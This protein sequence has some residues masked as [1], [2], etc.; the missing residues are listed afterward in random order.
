MKNRRELY[1]LFDERIPAWGRGRATVRVSP[2]DAPERLIPADV[3]VKVEPDILELEQRR[4]DG[5]LVIDIG[6][7]QDFVMPADWKATLTVTAKQTSGAMKQMGKVLQIGGMMPGLDPAVLG[8]F[9]LETKINVVFLPYGMRLISSDPVRGTRFEVGGTQWGS[10]SSPFIPIEADE[11]SV[12]DLTVEVFMVD[13]KGRR[14]ATRPPVERWEEVRLMENGSDC[15][16]LAKAEGGSLESLRLRLRS[17]KAISTGQEK[18][19][20]SFRLT[21]VMKGGHR[22][23][24][25][26]TI[27]PG[28][29]HLRFDS[30]KMPS[31]LRLGIRPEPVVIPMEATIPPGEWCD[32]LLVSWTAEPEVGSFSPASKATDTK[33]LVS[34]RFQPPGCYEWNP[35]EGTAQD[36]AIRITAGIGESRI[37][38][39]SVSLPCRWDAPYLWQCSIGKLKWDSGSVLDLKEKVLSEELQALALNGGELRVPVVGRFETPDRL[40]LREPVLFAE[41]WLQLD[42]DRKIQGVAGRE[43][44]EVIFEIPPLDAE[45]G[46]REKV[47][48][49]AVTLT[50]NKIIG[51]KLRLIQARSTDLD[52]RLAKP[53]GEFIERCLEIMANENEQQLRERGEVFNRGI[54]SVAWF[55]DANARIGGHLEKAIRV[56]NGI[57][58]RLYGSIGDLFVEL[59]IGAAFW[60]GGKAW[61]TF[62]KTGAEEVGKKMAG[63]VLADIAETSITRGVIAETFEQASKNLA[64]SSEAV[65][66]LAREV[67]D[68]KSL[69]GEVFADVTTA[70]GQKKLPGS[71]RKFK[72]LVENLAK[73][74]GRSPDQVM[75]SLEA[76]RKIGRSPE[77][78]AAAIDSFPRI[79][80]LVR[81]LDGAILENQ[82]NR[83]IVE[84]CK[85]QREL[86][87]GLAEAAREGNEK[88]VKETLS[89]L[90]ENTLS[91]APEVIKRAREVER[92]VVQTLGKSLDLA[93]HNAYAN[94]IEELARIGDPGL[95]AGIDRKALA[96][97]GKILR[98]A[99]EKAIE[100]EIAG[101]IMGVFGETMAEPGLKDYLDACAKEAREQRIEYN[102][103]SAKTPP[104]SAHQISPAVE[105]VVIGKS[106]FFDPNDFGVASD[107]K[108]LAPS[109][110]PTLVGYVFEMVGYIVSTVFGYAADGA[111]KLAEFAQQ[112]GASSTVL[113]SGYRKL[114]LNRLERFGLREGCLSFAHESQAELSRRLAE[115]DDEGLSAQGA[116]ERVRAESAD[117]A[118]NHTREQAKSAKDS[119]FV[120]CADALRADRLDFKSLHAPTQSEHHFFFHAQ[121]FISKINQNVES[122]EKA[123]AAS[124]QGLPSIIWNLMEGTWDSVSG[125]SWKIS[126]TTIESLFNWVMW[127]GAWGVRLIGAASL[128]ATPVVPPAAGLGAFLLWVGDDIIDTANHIGRILLGS[129]GALRDMNGM[130]EDFLI[131]DGIIHDAYFPDEETS[132]VE[133]LPVDGAGQLEIWTEKRQAC[134]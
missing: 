59:A 125:F 133:G 61:K 121:H 85:Q 130:V 25:T 3:S 30:E 115:S 15:F 114:G 101:R 4:E 26:V 6:T 68:T 103:V 20:P 100:E 92:R 48:S 111:V 44:K 53:A 42:A 132:N 50:P 47:T 45:S 60:A 102:Q 88:V 43:G 117:W 124:D 19:S 9:D 86:F 118:D 22:F 78:A 70:L 57:L 71:V 58:K 7:K 81:K 108:R 80:C 65:E 29:V 82:M 23:S 120:L 52:S 41:G 74:T 36:R 2:V 95:L 134:G 98:A 128:V 32:D 75:E 10:D 105:T 91:D 51:E 87:K 104:P 17:T 12:R 62:G 35:K 56:R 16:E 69:F 97:Y 8:A 83:E 31:E 5:K 14:T 77:V 63:N 72:K 119:L 113:S 127:A 94:L 54:L 67:V 99:D 37:P 96:A 21:P 122:Y 28:R 107:T 49:S 93:D 106:D 34:T 84:I 24:R 27:E 90:T 126:W 40:Y 18:V 112:I 73:K 13:A 123:A 39:A 64:K 46:Q 89:K 131:A 116:R 110:S 66:Q 109:N 11:K 129:V 76:V 38:A 1:L 79:S 55:L 33:G